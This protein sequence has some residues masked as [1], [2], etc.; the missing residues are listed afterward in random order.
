VANR[1]YNIVFGAGLTT[2]SLPEKTGTVKP[3]IVDVQHTW[4]FE[5]GR[6]IEF[7][8]KTF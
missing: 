4:M 5:V 6:C 1:V 2:F 8:F 3:M 7:E